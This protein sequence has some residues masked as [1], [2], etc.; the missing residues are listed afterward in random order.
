MYEH[1]NTLT[2]DDWKADEK[3]EE[4]QLMI[5]SMFHEKNRACTR[6][7]KRGAEW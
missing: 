2:V 6:E 1:M 5:E 3:Q 7:R 4:Y